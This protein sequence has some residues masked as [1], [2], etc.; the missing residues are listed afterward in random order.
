[1]TPISARSRSSVTV[2]CSVSVPS[3]CLALMMTRRPLDPRKCNVL[4]DANAFDRDGGPSDADV[5]RL[6]EL[7]RSQKVI[8]IAPGSVRGEIQNPRTPGHVQAAAL[9]Q[10]FSYGVEPNDSERAR[11]REVRDILRGNATDDRHDADARH[12][13][14]AAKY[15]GYFITHDRRINRTKR[16]DLEQVLPRSLWI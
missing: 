16:A 11:Y 8:L 6:L 5:D 14:E 2:G 1:M 9:P 7:G 12:V 13:V 10:I 3:G 15:G 4:F